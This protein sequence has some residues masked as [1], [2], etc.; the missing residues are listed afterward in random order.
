MMLQ[1]KQYAETILQIEN[2]YQI[3]FNTAEEN[4]TAST[5]QQV[6]TFLCYQQ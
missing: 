1:T 4:I 3:T 2:F 5:A 6:K